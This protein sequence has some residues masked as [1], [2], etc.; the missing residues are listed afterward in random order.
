V[1]ESTHEDLRETLAAYAA[2]A[3]D[4]EER[5]SI[6]R[7]L[8]ECPLCRA[9]VASYREA[10]SLLVPSTERVARP[11]FRRRSL[12]LAGAVAVAAIAVVSAV[13]LTRGSGPAPAR[14]AQIVPHER[15]EI[16]GQ[17]KLFR[18]DSPDGVVV[19]DLTRIAPPPPGHHYEVWVLRRP[20]PQAMEAVGS[21]TPQGRRARFRLPLPGPGTYRALDISIQ[22]DGGPA[23]HSQRSVG[24]AGFS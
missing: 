17:A 24:G 20:S 7:H 4:P 23:T 3:V 8:D 13:L 18:P 11:T 22:R 9:E 15:S 2:D 19:V 6:E 16:A 21:F 1:S 10:L 12:A 5:A 14:V